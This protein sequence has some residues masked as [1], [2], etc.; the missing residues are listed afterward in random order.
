MLKIILTSFIALFFTACLST[1]SILLPQTKAPEV[2]D[3]SSILKITIPVRE[4][5]YSNFDT[6]V[7][8][9]KNDLD[10]FIQT[11]QKQ[12]SWNKKENFISS[13]TLFPIDFKKY[14]ILLYRM[15]ETSGSTVLA[16]DVPKGTNKHVLI[17]IGRDKPNGG[18]ADMAYYALAYKVA[19]S[20][21]DITFDNGVKKH[22]IKN[23][24][25]NIQKKSEVPKGCLEW[26]DGCNDCGRVGNDGDAVCT[27]R[28]CIHK[29]KFK[30]TKWEENNK[31]IKPS[32]PKSIQESEN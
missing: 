31:S 16:V 4:Q 21:Q 12:K 8:S 24:S 30:C 32:L 22:I 20:V 14:N 10:D 1:S 26:Y 27:E 5:G 19:K 23:K 25:L 28:Y 3:K 2:L 18:T 13:L 7:L 9:S 15:T 29:D 11:I 17:E 6:Q